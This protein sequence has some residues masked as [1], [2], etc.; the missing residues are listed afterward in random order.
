MKIKK[1]KSKIVYRVIHKATGIAQYKEGYSGFTDDTYDFDSVYK[2]RD[3]D[4]YREFKDKKKYNIAKYKVI[5]ELIDDN[6]DN[7]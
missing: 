3:A 4:F 6:C 2:A 5:Y 1:V 7:K